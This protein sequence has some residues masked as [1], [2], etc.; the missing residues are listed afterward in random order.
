MNILTALDSGFGVGRGWLTLGANDA[1]GGTF[2]VIGLVLGGRFD[3]GFF[4]T[5]V[6]VVVGKF[7]EE[8]FVCFGEMMI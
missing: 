4:S 6:F 7:E 1:L 5:L 2:I 3:T 8:F